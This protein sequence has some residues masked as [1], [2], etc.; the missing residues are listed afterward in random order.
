[1]AACR[2]FFSFSCL[3][4]CLSL[5]FSQRMI[6]LIL[7]PFLACQRCWITRCCFVEKKEL[8]KWLNYVTTPVLNPRRSMLG[9]VFG[10]TGDSQDAKQARAKHSLAI[11]GSLPCTAESF[12][13]PILLSQPSPGI[14]YL[15]YI[16]P[17][18]SYILNPS[19]YC[20]III[21]FYK[22]RACCPN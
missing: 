11:K 21:I 16:N 8:K 13:R 19:I 17:S 3:A 1:M 14:F 15:R 5:R 9:M 2:I 22:L 4:C 10:T 12:F 6:S 18:T 7:A 20:I